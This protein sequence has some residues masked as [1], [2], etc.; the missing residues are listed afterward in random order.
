MSGKKS[1]QNVVT[2]TDSEAKKKAAEERRKNMDLSARKSK[3][4]LSMSEDNVQPG[5]IIGKQMVPVKGVIK[6]ISISA[7]SLPP[8]VKVNFISTLDAHERRDSFEIGEGF[9]EI[10]SEIDVE[11][12]TIIKCSLS[13]SGERIEEIF[14]SGI[15]QPK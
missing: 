11:K 5:E 15:I 4:L 3:I 10:Q 7:P 9:N 8:G 14:I 6:N 2:R 12:G 13:F 1:K